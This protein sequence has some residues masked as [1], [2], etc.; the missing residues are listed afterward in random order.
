ML[1][2]RSFR[3]AVL[4]LLLAS[5]LAASHAERPPVRV[6][7]TADGLG[8]ET[9]GD[10]FTDSRGFLWFSTT[11]GLSRFDGYAYATYSTRDGLPDR[12]VSAVRETSDG[13]LWVATAGGVCQ[14][15]ARGTAGTTPFTRVPLGDGP[16]ANDVDSLLATRDGR[17]WC[18]TER[19]LFRL[20]R[21]G[22]AWTVE[23]IDGVD[24][25]VYC[26][27]ED[28]WGEVWGGT[29]GNL[30]R[31]SPEGRAEVVPLPA[32]LST[33]LVYSLYEDDEARLWVG[34]RSEGL[35]RSA[36]RA[37]ADAPVVLSKF[38]GAAPT[39]W[40]F[41]LR[42]TRDGTL[43]AAT[44]TGLWRA[45]ANSARFERY[46]ALDGACDRQIVSLA[47]DRDG[48]MWVASNCG[49]LRVDRSG[50]TGYGT[51]DGLS[52]TFVNSIFES[53]AGD[54]VVVTNYER[55]DLHRFD[56]ARF[57]AAPHVTNELGYSGW[58]WGQTALQDRDGAWWVVTG[59]GAFRYPA[60]ATPD[61]A[62]RGRPERMTTGEAFRL[63]E[64][65]RGDVWIAGTAPPGL[66]RWDRATDRVVDLTAETGV[67]QTADYA[68]LAETADGAV[69]VGTGGAGL[70]RYANGRFERFGPDQ[71]ALAGWLR[72]LHVD[73][74]GR[75]WI[76]SS[77]GGLGRVDAPTAASPSFARVTTAEGLA[78]D[79]VWTVTS[80]AWG[81]LYAGTNR[82]VDRLD[83]VTGRIKHFTSADGCP[84]GHGLAAFRDRLGR[85]WFGT[86]FGLARFDP[87]PEREREP[88]RTLVVGVRVAGVSRPVSALGETAIPEMALGASENSVSVDFLGLGASI[89]EELRYQFRL[90]G[91]DGEWSAPSA[92]RTVTFANLAPGAYRFLVRAV[93]GD[94]NASPEPAV[95]AF[96]VAAPVWRRWWVLAL[97]ASLVAAAAYALYRYRLARLLEVE[98]VRTRIATDLHDDIGANLTRI[99]VLSEVARGGAGGSSDQLAAI[100]GISRESVASMS[101]IVWAINPKKDSLGDM[102]TRMRRFADEAFASRGVELEF[103]GPEHEREMKLGHETRRQ[104]FLLF[105]ECVTNAV[106]HAGCTRAE[107][108]LSIEG[109]HLVLTVSDDGRG[110]DPEVPSDG[111]G[112]ESMRR[113]AVALGGELEIDSA[114]GR[115]TRVRVTV[116]RGAVRPVHMDR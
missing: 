17:L 113:R 94:D 37:S 99:A 76:A 101:D 96:T 112:L 85:L 109:R 29:T 53:R 57:V 58:G 114:P 97:G 22:D 1:T 3:F 51:A 33:F 42:R 15:D 56:G 100:A 79:N 98:R 41:A 28:R 2:S 36:P 77:L 71:G 69:W 23:R 38:E 111:N 80:D 54:L 14:F 110:F 89:G 84:K 4:L 95:V 43:W 12:R 6:Y 31:V 65:S 93:D 108:E 32:N 92:E 78:S 75:L 102:I 35:L 46:G 81:R 74:A 83:P 106:R 105:K 27:L 103:R 13:T 55:R 44:T 7:G 10:I 67:G 62:L 68:S 86:E 91:A 72:A 115:G 19:G 40:I 59:G 34:L 49:V 45:S 11:D 48:N 52:I 66:F 16:E 64:D 63:F 88:P 20:E 25:G 60:A 5:P 70:L 18:G 61:E 107:V 82:G 30:W 9:V 104:L 47:E 50:F 73:G 116:S 21:A 26:L 39:G 87:E 8:A 90:D 24:K